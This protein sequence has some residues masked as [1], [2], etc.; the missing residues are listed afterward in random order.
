MNNIVGNNLVLEQND[1]NINISEKNYDNINI[2]NDNEDTYNIYYKS[3]VNNKNDKDINNSFKYKYISDNNLNKISIQKLNQNDNLKFENS[4][5]I[6]EKNKQLNKNKDIINE[7]ILLKSKI[8]TLEREISKFDKQSKDINIYMNL[9]FEFFQNINQISM[10]Q[11]NIE[12]DKNQF[13][14]TKIDLNLF[15]NNLN[16][17]E[18][19][20]FFLQNQ[21]NNFKETNNNKYQNAL[22]VKEYEQYDYIKNNKRYDIYSIQNDVNK[23]NYKQNNNI[24]KI[25]DQ[26]EIYKTLEERINILEKELN[27]QKQNFSNNNNFAIKKLNG[28]ERIKKKK[29]SKKKLENLNNI[30]E[31]PKEES[32][33]IKIKNK[34]KKNKLSQYM[35][36]IN[37]TNDNLYNQKNKLNNNN[38]KKVILSNRKNRY[39]IKD[40]ENKKRSVTPLN[41]KL[42]RYFNQ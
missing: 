18:K 5:L 17:I 8:E 30:Y 9:F 24:N 39:N 25:N 3:N 1:K 7:N 2:I 14:I 4:P 15:Q 21:L 16:K 42:K 36:N 41:S 23:I 12:I 19:Y 20:V 32:K 31:L 33:Q 27:L 38:L 22:E 37:N 29:T 28:I 6:K 10:N 34:Q 35:K 40:K 26:N 11:L 13:N